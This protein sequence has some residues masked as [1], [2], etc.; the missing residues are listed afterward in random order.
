LP[1]V[2]SFLS[3]AWLISAALLSAVAVTLLFRSAAVPGSAKLLAALGLLVLALATGQPQWLTRPPPPPVEVYVDLSPSTRGATYRVRRQLDQRLADLLDGAPFRI[4]Y[5]AATAT[6]Q[7]PAGDPLPDLPAEQTTFAPAPTAAAVVLFSDGRFA[8]PPTAPPVYAV[9]D[10]ALDRPAD[11]AV[12]AIESPSASVPPR[13]SIAN[14][15]GPRTLTWDGFGSA[16][17]MGIASGRYWL[18]ASAVVDRPLQPFGARLSPGDAWPENDAMIAIVPPPASLQRWWVGERA[19]PSTGWTR[20]APNELPADRAAYLAAA[21]VALDNLPANALPPGRAGVLSAYVRELGGTL[22]LVGGDRAFAAGGY[23]GTAL[24]ALSPLASTPPEPVDRWTVLIDAS[25]SMAAPAEIA[26]ARDRRFDVAVRAAMALVSSLPPA[27]IVDVGSFARDV[28]WWSRGRDAGATSTELTTT[29]RK[30]SPN[31]PTNLLPAIE[32][33]AG[34][35]TSAMTPRRIILLT[36]GGADPLDIATVTT[37]LRATSATLYVL[38]IGRGPATASLETVAAATGGTVIDEADPS[39]WSRA[40]GE[41]ARAAQPDHLQR[42]PTRATFTGELAKVGRVDVAP[43]WNRTWPRQRATLVAT[44]TTGEPLAAWWAAGNGRVAA[45]AFVAPPD[46]V[47]SLAGTLARP[48]RDERFTITWSDD[49]AGVGVTVVAQNNDGR[50]LNEAPLAAT[51]GER[52]LPVPQVGPGR[53]ELSID[54]PR[55]PTVGT[56]THAGRVID[57]RPLAGHYAPEFA[58]IGNDYFAM[59]ELATRTGGRLIGPNDNTAID[60]PPARVD[61]VSLTPWIA[62]LGTISIST[63]LIIWRRQ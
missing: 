19:P 6:D 57:R 60:L 35:Q 10:A 62:M 41:L 45:T 43:P 23:P 25:G 51:F 48:P 42:L 28:R 8:L 7:P 32:S 18:S 21:V 26:G 11:A 33:T 1:S 49:A 36:D 14:A 4:H 59:R 15:G 50:P 13:A 40:A 20:I 52:S 5:F 58:A 17:T 29:A 44:A 56:V 27:D 61:R 38:A 12:L 3:P 9:I 34:E 24:D 53:Y 63:A 37:R 22:F 31:G 30:I 16:P 47:D 39:R 2:V 55:Q 46:V 54:A